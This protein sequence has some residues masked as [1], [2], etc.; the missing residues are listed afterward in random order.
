[1]LKINNPIASITLME[2][3]NFSNLKRVKNVLQV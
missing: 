1:M 3:D 2:K